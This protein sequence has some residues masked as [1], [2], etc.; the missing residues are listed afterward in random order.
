MTFTDLPPPYGSVDGQ[1]SNFEI[2]ELPEDVTLKQVYA[3]FL[4]YIWGGVRAFFEEKLQLENGRKIWERLEDDI[5]VIICTPNGWDISQYTFLRTAG[6]EAGL[7]NETNADKRLEFIT[8]AEASLHFALEYTQSP[9]W[10]EDGTM[11]AIVDAGG[12]TVDSTLYECKSTN[13]LALE[14][15]CTSECIQVC[16]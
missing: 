16:S 13:P 14:E 12:S 8:E 5:V 10:L 6:I 1:P 15:I 7:V 11:L 9:N 2:P 3:D 4:K